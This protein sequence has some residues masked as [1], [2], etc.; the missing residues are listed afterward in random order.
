[1]AIRSLKAFVGDPV[2]KKHRE[3]PLLAGFQVW[4]Q[5]SLGSGLDPLNVNEV[6]VVLVMLVFSPL[7][8]LWFTV[9]VFI[10]DEFKTWPK[11][12]RILSLLLFPLFIPLVY[13]GIIGYHM[14]YGTMLRLYER[15]KAL[16]AADRA[17]RDLKGA[18]GLA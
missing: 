15:H 7:I 14:I 11:R 13:F 4:V 8:M 6:F 1:M 12:Q 10:G 2:P 17:V 18:V 9:L 5:G 16:R 3:N